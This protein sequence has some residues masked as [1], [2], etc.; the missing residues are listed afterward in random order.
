M[1]Q[2]AGITGYLASRIARAN[3]DLSFVVESPV[4]ENSPWFGDVFK[5]NEQLEP[6]LRGRFRFLHHD[7][8]AEQPIK[9]A[10]LYWLATVLHK[11]TDDS[12]IDILRKTIVAMDPKKSRILTRDIVLDG[13]DP[14]PEDLSSLVDGQAVNGGK[15]AS[16]YQPGLGPTGTITRLNCGIEF[17]V[18][19]VMNAYERTRAEWIAVFKKADPRLTL[20][21]C[22]QT[23]GDCA[24]L[25]EWALEG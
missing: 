25:M 22:Y 12:V 5:K 20:K 19:S 24:S 18:L 17:Q 21:G 4:A 14:V 9:G 8:H 23:I 1:I 10:E 3:P 13:G 6:D 2:I 7:N 11:E 16:E 15:K